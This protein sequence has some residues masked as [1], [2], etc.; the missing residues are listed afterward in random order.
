[1]VL[2]ALGL[3]GLKDSEVRELIKVTEVITG[4]TEDRDEVVNAFAPYYRIGPFPP[5]S[6]EADNSTAT[7]LFGT[8]TTAW[9]TAWRSALHHPIHVLFSSDVLAEGVNLQDAAALINFDVHWNPVRMIQRSGRIDRRLNPRIEKAP[10]F[11]ELEALAREAKVPVPPY[12]WQGRDKEA[13]LTVNMILP[14]ELEAELLLRERIA[15][16]TLAIDFTLGL[17]QGTG[18]EADWMADYAYQGVSSLNA[19]Q[20]DRAIE[21]VASYHEKFNRIFKDRGMQ[22]EWAAKLDSWFRAGDADVSSPLV[23]RS[24]LGRRGEPIDRFERCSRYLEPGLKDGIPY[25]CW[26]EKIPGES[27][28]DGWLI[29]DG[30]SEHWPP[31]PPTREIDFRQES[32]SPVK[33]SHLLAAALQLEQG[34][35]IRKLP[36]QEFVK[37]FMQGATALAAPK[38][39]A[40]DD[41]VNIG[42]HDLYILQLP[43]FDPEKLGRK[44]S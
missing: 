17:D 11:P 9:A 16:K 19:F 15:M 30:K 43:V 37:P 18:A 23:A 25:W 1:M 10:V 22:P 34:I 27:L 38:L 24:L 21:Q 35:E 7:S 6:E 26:A 20:R 41:R 31:P 14:D 29:M 4:G 36:P 13:P 39:G 3:P 40:H 44:V 32:A 42:F 8:V 5:N 28:F 33:A 2:P 12:Y